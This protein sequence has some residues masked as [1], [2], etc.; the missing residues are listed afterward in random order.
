MHCAPLAVTRYIKK[1][2]I[3]RCL[4]CTI[5][6]TVMSL[7]LLKSNKYRLENHYR[8]G[9]ENGDTKGFKDN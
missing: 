6:A 5:C 7:S 1:L 9:D 8:S 2:L 4:E 3:K